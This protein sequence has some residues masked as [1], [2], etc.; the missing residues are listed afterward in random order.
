MKTDTLLNV[1]YAALFASLV[2]V[3]IV[4]TAYMRECR[5]ARIAADA[6]HADR[7]VFEGGV[8]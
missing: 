7:V 8:K 1:F 3:Y 6:A 4:V 5:D 2:G